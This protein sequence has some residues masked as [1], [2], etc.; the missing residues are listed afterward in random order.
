MDLPDVNVWV[1]LSDPRHQF[2]HAARL[3]WDNLLEDKCAFCRVTLLGWFRISTNPK[4]MGGQPFTNVQL[5][6]IYKRLLAFPEVCF[7]AEPPDID[8]VFA[9]FSSE[10]GMPHHLWTDAYLAA[11][12]RTANCRLVSFDSD[13]NRFGGVRF[14]QLESR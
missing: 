10:P 12:A 6:N 14:L 2:H 4:A 11:F 3:Y 1:A 8:T 5:W 7:L 9:E 13:F